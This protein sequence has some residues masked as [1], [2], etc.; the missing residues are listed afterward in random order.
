MLAGFQLI[1]P[2]P[3]QTMRLYASR[4]SDCANSSSKNGELNGRHLFF[5][6]NLLVTV[7]NRNQYYPPNKNAKH[8]L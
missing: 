7:A 3:S 5:G 4:Q 1:H 6:L 2:T 8:W